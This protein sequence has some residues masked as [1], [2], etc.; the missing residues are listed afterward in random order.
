MSSARL[1]ISVVGIL[2]VTPDSFSDGGLYSDPERAIAHAI[3]LRDQGADII[4]IGADSTRPGSACVGVEQ[5]WQRLAP[6]M[7]VLPKQIPIS[8]DT[9][10][11]EVAQRAL[12]A[13]A[14]MINDI[15]GGADDGMFELLA[16]KD[17]KLVLMFSRSS[18]PHN[19]THLDQ[20]QGADVVLESLQFFNSTL[21]RAM[22]AGV[23]IEQLV[24]DP[25]MGAFLSRDPL[26]SW[27]VIRSLPEFEKLNKSIML[28][29]SRKGF[30]K[31]P[32]EAFPIERDP[33]SALAGILAAQNLAPGT[34]LY[35]RTHNV[36]M[37]KA[38]L[39]AAGLTLG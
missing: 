21:K 33:L 22:A 29:V 30:L 15:S 7:A 24:L 31:Q 17:A 13:G 5:E 18:E 25:G 36:A 16:G 6:L 32:E 14:T 23:A 12:A 3:K 1:S 38:F 11:V 35:L 39:H 37:T 8:V 9:H 34:R 26:V 2:N 28:S 20:P 10:H 4:D 27:N 19:F